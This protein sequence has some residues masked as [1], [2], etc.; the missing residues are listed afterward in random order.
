MMILTMNG[1]K[2]KEGA[3]EKAKE[4]EKAIVKV[5]MKFEVWIIL[6]FLI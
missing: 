6:S 2:E 5:K 3:K 1:A 4:R